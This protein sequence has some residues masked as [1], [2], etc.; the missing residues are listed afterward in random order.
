MKKTFLVVITLVVFGNLK[1]QGVKIGVKAGANINKLSGVSFSD[2]YN[3]S[4][5][6]GGF[7]EIDFSKKIGIQPEILFSQSQTNTVSGFNSIYTGISNAVSGTSVKYNQL[8]IPILLRYNMGKLLTI[9]VG[10]QYSIVINQNENLLVNGKN[11]FKTG[12]FSLVSG[13]QLNLGSL[14]VYGRYNIG[15][16][17]INDIDNKDQWK[18]Q[19][20]QLGFGFRF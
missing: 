15:L 2:A 4:Y 20:M 16:S 17:N 5:Q 7:L 8:N 12:D 9:N 3:L 19:Q 1:A 6:V 10:P 11:A 18:S 14:R 13:V